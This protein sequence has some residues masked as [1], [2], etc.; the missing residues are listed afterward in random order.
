MIIIVVVITS[1]TTTA[2][3]TIII[4]TISKPYSKN[5]IEIV[6]YSSHCEWWNKIIE[7]LIK[8][9]ACALAWHCALKCWRKTYRIHFP[10]ITIL[11]WLL[12]FNV[13][14]VFA[15]LIKRVKWKWIRDISHSTIPSAKCI[16]VC[17]YFWVRWNNE[18]FFF[19]LV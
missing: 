14:W 5:Y 8:Y 19:L 18:C 6:I 15:V 1:T 16:F 10:K 9:F 12:L 13:G 4:I 2:T 17:R 3:T 7:M 11:S